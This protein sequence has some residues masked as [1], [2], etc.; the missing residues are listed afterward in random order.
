[1]ARVAAVH[2]EITSPT[3]REWITFRDPSDPLHEIRADVTWLTSRWTCVFG[4]SCHGVVEG[5]PSDGCCS[6]GAFFSDKSDEKKL[7]RSAKLLDAS[8]WQLHKEGNRHGIVEMD[9]AH[10]EKR[11][12]TATFDGACVFLNRPGFAE[13]MGCS[14]HLYAMKNGIHPL[15]VKPD[16]CWQLPMVREE[17]DQERTDG[18]EVRVTT[19]TEFDRG[20]WGPGGEDLH[21]WCTSSPEAHISSSR[22]HESYGPEIAALIGSEAQVELSRLM[23][24]RERI[25]LVAPH[26]ATVAA[27]AAAARTPA[28]ARK[29]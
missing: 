2:V 24:E 18:T 7:R 14:L 23:A 16:I 22:V 15:E 6:H 4:A 1:L 10:G 5:R 9:E 28:P 21:W 11:K 3:T 27:E 29:R 12:R 8:V 17:E 13:G 20:R 25:G 19:L 26:P